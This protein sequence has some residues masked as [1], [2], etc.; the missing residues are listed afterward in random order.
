MFTQLENLKGRFIEVGKTLS[1]PAT[2]SDMKRFTQLNKEYREL[3]TIVK[4]Y[5]EYQNVLAKSL[6]TVLGK[7]PRNSNTLLGFFKTRPTVS[8]HKLHKDIPR[9]LANILFQ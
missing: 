5:D 4:V 6:T 9:K 7:I 2:I 1:D 3:E 8:K